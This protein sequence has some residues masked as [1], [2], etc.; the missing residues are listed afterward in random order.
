MERRRWERGRSN[1]LE[2][3][4]RKVEEDRECDK[5]LA[6]TCTLERYKLWFE[7]S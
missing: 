1:E 2:G 3:N 4:E 6:V 7:L 5:L